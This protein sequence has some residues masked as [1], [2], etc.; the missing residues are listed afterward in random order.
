M[1]GKLKLNLGAVTNYQGGD[2]TVFKVCD[3]LCN[4]S[5]DSLIIQF[6]EQNKLLAYDGFSPNNDGKNDVWE[7]QNVEL[8]PNAQIQIFSRWGSLIFESSDLNNEIGIWDGESVPDG[9]Y[10]YTLRLNNE[11]EEVITGTILLSR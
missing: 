4:C 3:L 8:Y 7:I 10:Y 1:N 9:V 2:T 6:K 5:Q 11:A